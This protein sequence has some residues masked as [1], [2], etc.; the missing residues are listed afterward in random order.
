M[1]AGL[2][3]RVVLALTVSIFGGAGA[4]ARA[5][6]MEDADVGRCI[7]QAAGN[8]L[9]LERTLWG[10]RDNEG[11]WVGAEI[12]NVNGSHDLGPL[13][14][15]SQWVRRL[16]TVAR[17]P[18]ERVRHLLI[19]D[20]CYN[21]GAARWLFLT[22]LQATGDYWIAVGRY[23]SPNPKRASAY[24]QAV[25]RRLVTRFGPEV[26]SRAPDSTPR[27]RDEDTVAHPIGHRPLG[28]RSY[29]PWPS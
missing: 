4:D 23:H 29:R 22:A 25:A 7:R 16:A 13:Q 21:V 10:L 3:W 20:P 5:G 19:H 14:I 9:W 12:A 28:G 24:A 15:N 11:G 26:F 8:R 1:R 2:Y 27:S 18:A 6:S 17:I